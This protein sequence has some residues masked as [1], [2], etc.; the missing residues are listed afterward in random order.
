MSQQ[1]YILVSTDT[2]RTS[3]FGKE[4][5]QTSLVHWDEASWLFSEL[6]QVPTWHKSCSS[7]RGVL[8]MMTKQDI[9]VLDITST[10]QVHIPPWRK[11]ESSTQECHQM[12][13]VS[14]MEGTVI[15]QYHCTTVVT[16]GP[17]AARPLQASPSWL[18]LFTLRRPLE[19][20]QVQKLEES[21]GHE[22]FFSKE[23]ANEST[24]NS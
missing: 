10:E 21:N 9:S 3:F 20:D 19:E 5:F 16:R 8:W 24:S 13:Y 7:D 18:P 17:K 2:S 1:S 14:S 4:A 6:C 12:G 22:S 15:T 11:R 23:S